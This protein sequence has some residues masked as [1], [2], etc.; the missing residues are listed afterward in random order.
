ME[1]LAGFLR[2]AQGSGSFLATLEAATR[3]Q[4]EGTGSGWRSYP[5]ADTES[6]RCR[7]FRLA[8][9]ARIPLHDHRDLRGLLRI[10][11]GTLHIERF[12][13]TG[14]RYPLGGTA[15][16]ARDGTQLLGTGAWASVDGARGEVHGLSNPGP[17]PLLFLDVVWHGGLD[18][19]RH[20][21]FPVGERGGELTALVVRDSSIQR[22]RDPHAQ[23]RHS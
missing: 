17:D 2:A 8:P 13:L 12:R 9:G 11:C 22:L 21:F 3:D 7:L 20:L 18:P 1:D 5:V 10:V 19:E 6:M 16:L 23:R 14:H 15:S 4:R